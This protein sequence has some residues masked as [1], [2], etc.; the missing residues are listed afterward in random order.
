[1]HIYFTM[2]VLPGIF[3]KNKVVNL[4]TLSLYKKII[5]NTGSFQRKRLST[6]YVVRQLPFHL[7]SCELHR[8]N[9]FLGH[10]PL[11]KCFNYRTIAMH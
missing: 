4:L 11:G 5:E 2:G 8:L 6:L 7:D 10:E 1:M 9:A 3:T